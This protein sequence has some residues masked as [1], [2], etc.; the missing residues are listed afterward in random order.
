MRQFK[1]AMQ[2]KDGWREVLNEWDVELRDR[3]FVAHGTEI[4]LTCSQVLDSA[5]YIASAD[6]QLTLVAASNRKTGAQ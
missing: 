1:V 6:G 4:F 5:Y 3:Q 2:L